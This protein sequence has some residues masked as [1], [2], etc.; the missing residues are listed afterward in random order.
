MKN[1][2]MIIKSRDTGKIIYASM[3]VNGNNINLY[4][5][6]FKKR[7]ITTTLKEKVLPNL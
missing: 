5:G 3:Y 1:L 2:R 7:K 6:K 4:N